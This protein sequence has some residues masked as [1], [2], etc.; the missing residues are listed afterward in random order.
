MFSL[1]AGFV[2]PGETIESAVR[3]EVLEESAVRVGRV[4]Y[5][6]CQPWPFPM[7]LMFGCQGEALSEEITL[8]PVELAAARWVDRAEA[9]EIIAG[10]HPEMNAP[11][12]GAIAASLIAAW[13][14][15]TL[16][17]PASWEG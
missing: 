7:S 13:A 2:E 17:D 15:G 12:P 1:L 10:R 9:A 5:V 16:L 4:R 14:A 11:R 8:D 3:R 6:A